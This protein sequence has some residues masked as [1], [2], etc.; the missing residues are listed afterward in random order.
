MATDS[1]SNGGGGGISQDT[2]LLERFS[3]NLPCGGISLLAAAVPAMVMPEVSP[4]SFDT[5]QHGVRIGTMKERPHLQSNRTNRLDNQAGILGAIGISHGRASIRDLA[6]ALGLSDSS[7]NHAELTALLSNASCSTA[8]SC[9]NSEH[10]IR[11]LAQPHVPVVLVPAAHAKFMPQFDDVLAEVAMPAVARDDHN[12]P[13][14]ELRL[15]EGE[16]GAQTSVIASRIAHAI[17]QRVG[18]RFRNR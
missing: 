1:D 2:A 17:A 10:C 18:R 12:L 6:I 15:M 8:F 4:D 13:P 11:R 16:N 14:P 5:S 7:T 3:T 9:T